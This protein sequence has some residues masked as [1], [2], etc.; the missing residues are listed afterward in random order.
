MIKEFLSL[1]GDYDD[2]KY[3]KE[4][5]TIKMGGKIAHYVEP[6]NIEDLSQIVTFLKNNHIEYKVLGNGSNLIAGSTEY[7]GVVISLTH[8]DNFQINEDCVYVEAGVLAPYLA[9]K[10]AA[11]GYSGFEFAS[12][13]PGSI[14]GLLYMNAGAY[15]SDMSSIVQEVLVYRKQELVWM[16]KEELKFSYRYSIFQEHPHWVILACKLS[17]TKGNS[18]EIF[19]LMMERL[20]RRKNTQP[21]DKLSAGSVFRNP[22]D[23]AAW[24][25]ID[26]LGYRG[27]E[28]NGVQVSEKH[29]NF[30]I[31]NGGGKAED[32]LRIAYNIQEE[33]LKKYGVKLIMEVE[34]FNC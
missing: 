1:H 29:S 10:L 34:K 16:K 6:Y 8:F 18:E 5:T 28:L 13:I 22:Q 9:N 12:G 2:N 31:N 27:Y 3:F 19:A 15:K 30:I 25:Y 7:E 24:K 23:V 26:E 32:F 4:L 21:L 33:A 11:K 20:Q 14:G 17:L